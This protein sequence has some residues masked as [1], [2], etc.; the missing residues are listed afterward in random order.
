M[1]SGRSTPPSWTGLTRDRRQSIHTEAP[2]HSFRPFATFWGLCVN[3]GEKQTRMALWQ[4]GSNLYGVSTMVGVNGG[5]TTKNGFGLCAKTCTEAYYTRIC[6]Y[7]QSTK[8]VMV[9][10]SGSASISQ[11]SSM[12]RAKTEKREE[13]LR[14]VPEVYIYLMSFCDSVLY[15]DC[16]LV[17]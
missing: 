9:Y 4:L 1:K 7:T 8:W 17:T 15:T 3:T 10:V 14:V 6:K 2:F 5:T 13:H 16:L 12:T 11:A